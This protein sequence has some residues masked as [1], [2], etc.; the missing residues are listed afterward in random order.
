MKSFSKD[1][2][3]RGPCA[4]LIGIY[5]GIATMENGM[6]VPKKIKNRITI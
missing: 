1:V 2:E 3:K 4:L 5:I 6:E